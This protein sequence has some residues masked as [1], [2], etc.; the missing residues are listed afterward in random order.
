MDLPCVRKSLISRL[1]ASGFG[2][3][4]ALET[5]FS[6]ACL[7]RNPESSIWNLPNSRAALQEGSEQR[8]VS[9]RVAFPHAVRSF[10]RSILPSMANIPVEER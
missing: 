9:R 10:K 7:A 8:S 6:A 4:L 2:L 1:T 5:P 3:F